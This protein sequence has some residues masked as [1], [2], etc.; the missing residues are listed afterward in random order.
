MKVCATISFVL[1]MAA[2]SIAPAAVVLQNATA[3]FSQAAG[4]FLVSQAIDGNLGGPSVNNGWAI[5]RPNPDPNLATFSEIAA[6]ETQTNPA[7]P[8]GAVLTFTMTQNWGDSHTIGRF[9]FSVTSDD[10]SLFADGLQNGG[11]VTANWL[12]LTP[13][14]ALATGGATL[15]VQGDNSILASGTNPDTSVYTVTA[16][17][18]LSNITG[19]RLEVLEHPSLP[20]NGPGRQPT[21]GNFV[22]TELEVEAIAVVPEPAMCLIF[23]VPVFVALTPLRRGLIR[24]LKFGDG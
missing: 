8:S 1:M 13:L 21:N 10:R 22:L 5:S 12:I 19:I 24:M 3:T 2:T 23:G 4:N 14:T 11:D 16:Y 18:T 7:G 9:R 6:F 20:F 17:S 15:T